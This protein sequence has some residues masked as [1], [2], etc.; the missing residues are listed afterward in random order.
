M[1]NAL[2]SALMA[3]AL[4]VSA[5]AVA[6]ITFYQGEN[7]HGKPF[8]TGRQ[9]ANLERFGFNDRASSAVVRGKAWEVCDDVRFGGRCV[10]LRPGDYPSLTAMGLSDRISSVREAGRRAPVASAPAA[11][12]ITFYER[13]EY[14]G[15]TFTT[16]Q[17]VRDLD[18]FG[19]NNRASSVVVV[20][21]RWEVCED[22]RFGGRCLTLR[23][24]NYPSLASMGLDRR[25]TSARSLDRHAG[26]DDRR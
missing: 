9:V 3:T 25:I 24:G 8:T 18:R 6:D 11:P 16:E 22:A 10:I 7:Y 1:K 26:Y 20:G 15:R 2:K 12:Q 21:D 19:F 23:P 17:P 13:E 5:N 4:F 14:R